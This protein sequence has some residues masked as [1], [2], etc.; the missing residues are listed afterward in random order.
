MYTTYDDFCVN[1]MYRHRFSS[2]AIWPIYPDDLLAPAFPTS[3]APRRLGPGSPY[4]YIHTLCVC[5]YTR[6]L[7]VRILSQQT[8]K[9]W[10]AS[11]ESGFADGF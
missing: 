5:V 11:S 9:F 1:D 7:Y 6:A 2:T 8:R 4:T 10:Q 3:G